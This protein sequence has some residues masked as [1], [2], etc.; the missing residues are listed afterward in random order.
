LHAGLVHGEGQAGT[1][2]LLE[3]AV[4]IGR[5]DDQGAPSAGVVEPELEAIG[6]RDVLGERE[7]HQERDGQVVVPKDLLHGI[8]RAGDRSTSDFP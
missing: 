8:Y 2:T 1:A 3:H 5:F 6:V 4:H 7:P